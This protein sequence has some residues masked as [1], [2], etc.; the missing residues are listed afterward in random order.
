MASPIGAGQEVAI[1]DAIVFLFASGVVIPLIRLARIPA[2]AGFVLAGILLGPFGL[3]ALAGSVPWLT[4]V[5]ISE[6]ETAAPF[7]E[8][9]VLFLLFLLGLELSFQK[10]WALRRMVFGAGT[11]Q[12][13]ASALVIGLAAFSVGQTAPAAAVIGLALALSSTAIVMQLLVEQRRA[14]TATGRSALGVLLFQDIL[15][16]PILIFVGFASRGSGGDLTGAIMQALA[17][18]FVAILIILVLGRFALSRVYRLAA[19]VGGRDELMALALLTVVGSAVITASAGLSLALGAFLAGLLLGETEFKH[20]TEIDLEPF[21]GLLLGLFFMTVGMGLDLTAILS[22]AGLVIGLLAGLLL[23]KLAIAM[24][25]CRLFGDRHVM[26]EAAFLLAPAGEFAFVILGAGLAGGVLDAITVSILAAVAGLS[27]LVTPALGQLGQVLAAKTAPPLESRIDNGQYTELEG[28]VILAGFG[29]VG[30]AIA[31][32]LESEDTDLVAL[33]RDAMRVSREREKGWKIYYGDASRPEMLEKAGAHGA[34]LFI[35]T[36]DDPA[37]AEA[38]V[39]AV[40][41]IRPAA[42]ILARAR[43]TD[44]ADQLFAAGATHVV[45]DAIEAGLQLASRALSEFGYGLDAVSDRIQA[46]RETAYA[47]ATRARPAAE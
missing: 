41:A 43:D 34:A 15:V 27:M 3:G 20:Q 7:A 4:Y 33:D 18:G 24:V 32:I 37:S 8:L 10:L 12:S 44:H 38:M 35:V 16:A 42:P 36:V 17:E 21:K 13:G 39:W 9:G 29:R 2:V 46:E 31:R 14:A 30:H 11:I 19:H 26:F 6:P 5:S 23:A 1:K 47:R 22:N 28:H 40:R 25:A 45:P